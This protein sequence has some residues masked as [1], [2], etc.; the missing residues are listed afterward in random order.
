MKKIHLNIGL[1]SLLTFGLVACSFVKLNPQAQTVTVIP[2][3]TMLNNC[4]YLGSTNAS[5]WSKA[6]TFQSQ[7]K[8]ESQLDT[9]A[10][11]EAAT[12]GG[13]TV[14]PTSVINNGQRAY[15]VYNCP[16]NESAIAM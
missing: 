9:L 15:S 8:V 4:K 13:N 6:D 1:L 2:S 14:M 7:A 12:M 11:N 5:L 16:A 10:R 3:N